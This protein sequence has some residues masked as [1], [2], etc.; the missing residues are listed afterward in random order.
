MTERLHTSWSSPPS[1]GV[2]PIVLL[3]GFT[4]NAAAWGPFAEHLARNRPVL[5]VDLPGHGGSDAVRADLAGAA[6][7]VADSL[8]D[9]DTPATVV[10]YSMGGRVAL[11]LALRHPGAIDRLVLVSTSAGIDDAEERARR[12]DADE[13]LA[14]RIEAIGVDAF[15]DEWLAQPLFASLSPA[16]AC[17]EARRRN[18]ATG[19][20]SSLRLCGT[21]T[22]EPLWTRL[23]SIDVPTLVVVG[24]LD[25]R[26]TALGERLVASIGPAA[27][28][29]V[30]EGAGHNAPLELPERTAAA[31]LD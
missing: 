28:L 31:I 24:G 4:Q 11:H 13:R 14:D 27:R 22:Q 16:A 2:S 9:L 1:D 30:I 3:H 20:A 8:G 18:T 17:R 15:L 7:L 12:R 29:V 25:E 5:A 26:F 19:L 23:G 21:G 6:A 10:G